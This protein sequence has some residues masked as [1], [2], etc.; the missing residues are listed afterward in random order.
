MSADNHNLTVTLDDKTT[1]SHL[2]SAV[3]K[4]GILV[5]E[6]QRMTRSLEDVY[7]EI[8]REAKN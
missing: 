6:A 3:V 5:E 2:L 1:S 8:M 7:I 4:H